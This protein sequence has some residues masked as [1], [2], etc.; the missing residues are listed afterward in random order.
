MSSRSLGLFSGLLVSHGRSS[1]ASCFLIS[2]GS[3]VRKRMRPCSR[4]LSGR[5]SIFR[6]RSELITVPEA[7]LSSAPEQIGVQDHPL[8]V[9]LTHE[10]CDK[11]DTQSKRKRVPHS[12]RTLA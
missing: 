4:T 3:S 6:S 7:F 5:F 10:R 12:S 8:I 11:R 9:T 2:S 1:P